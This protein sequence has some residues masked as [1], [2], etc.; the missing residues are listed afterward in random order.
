MESLAIEES[1]S[2]IPTSTLRESGEELK[3]QVWLPSL[4]PGADKEIAVGFED[5]DLVELQVAQPQ[6]HCK[7]STRVDPSSAAQGAHRQIG[8]GLLYSLRFCR[9]AAKAAAAA[10]AMAAAL[11]AANQR[12]PK[13]QS[14]YD[15]D[16]QM[17]V[18]KSGRA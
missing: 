4:L 17:G 11:L 16:H 12:H 3:Y 13:I 8:T 6:T 5:H 15:L 18:P 9:L 2:P 7:A 14:S 10:D 1:F